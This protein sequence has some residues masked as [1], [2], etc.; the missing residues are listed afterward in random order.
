MELTLAVSRS[1]LCVELVSAARRVDELLPTVVC[2]LLTITQSDLAI[3]K[4]TSFW[5]ADS[6]L[7]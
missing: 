5:K 2:G 7:Y 4:H 3:I 1:S 6:D